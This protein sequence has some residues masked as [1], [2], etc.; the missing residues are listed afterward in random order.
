MQNTA[1][2]GYGHTAM[3]AM[4]SLLCACC[5]CVHEIFMVHMWVGY[6]AVTVQESVLARTCAGPILSQGRAGQRYVCRPLLFTLP[7]HRFTAASILRRLGTAASTAPVTVLL[8]YNALLCKLCCM[9]RVLPSH[10][11]RAGAAG[12]KKCPWAL[13]LL[14]MLQAGATW[15]YSRRLLHDVA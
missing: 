10:D 15:V 7:V 3:L 11:L 9:L 5:A 4:L 14:R 13:G 8:R 1:R 12:G 6:T 2:P